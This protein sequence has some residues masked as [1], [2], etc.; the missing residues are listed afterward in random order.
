M[1]IKFLTSNRIVFGFSLSIS[2]YLV[3]SKPSAP[4]AKASTTADPPAC[5]VRDD[6]P[7]ATEE[8][9]KVAEIDRLDA[10][11]F[12]QL[13]RAAMTGKPNDVKKLLAAGAKIDVRQR[14]FHG[15]PLQYAASRGQVEILQA[16]IKAGAKIDARDT[17]N[18]TPLMWA[19]DKGQTECIRQLVKAKADVRAVN[20]GG[21]TALHYAA[22]ARKKA[23]A[24]LLVD[25]GART[26]ALNS[27][28]KTPLDLAPDLDLKLPAETPEEAATTAP[29]AKDAK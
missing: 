17:N 24:Q 20:N 10:S 5:A 22:Q 23:A 18:R 9:E 28:K 26:D 4:A 14:E 6:Q 16:L 13:H 1:I 29:V 27:Q 7:K 8:T 25:S 19:A 21:W 3:I 2:C 15:T 12:S 11:G